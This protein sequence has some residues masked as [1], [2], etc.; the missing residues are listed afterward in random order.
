MIKLLG[1]RYNSQINSS[2]Q[3]RNFSVTPFLNARIRTVSANNMIQAKRLGD[4]NQSLQ[5][6]NFMLST[7]GLSIIVVAG[8][9]Y[10]GLSDKLVER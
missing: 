10:V 6:I 7:I 2:S 8:M 4:I 5:D 3:L 9:L 1:A